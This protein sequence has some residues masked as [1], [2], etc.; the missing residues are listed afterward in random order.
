MIKKTIYIST[1]CSLKLRDNQLV[2]Q[3]NHIKGQEDKADRTA[4]IEDIGF[5]ILEHDQI[6]LSHR[7]IGAMLENN[8]AMITSNTK[9]L[10]TGLLLNLNGNTLQGERFK[11]QI[12]ASEP[13]KKQLW[14]QVIKQKITNQAYLLERES[15]NTKKMTN[16]AD[17][18]L[19]GD[20]GNNEAQAAAYYWQNIFAPSWEFK[21]DRE[22]LPPNNLLNYGYTILRAIMAR[23]LVGAG[24]LPTLGIFHRNRYNAYALADDMMEPYRPFVDKVVLNILSQTSHVDNLTTELK[25]KLLTIPTLDVKIE[26]ETSPLM[27]ATQRTAASLVKCFEGEKRRLLLP[28]ML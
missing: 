20:D 10:P 12:E 16:L 19:S 7:L 17:T 2:V 3:Y 1:P 27:I 26:K 18:V 24:L 4:P 22:G 5:L 9:L 21:R 8:V 13:L 6:T 14:A 28:N 15:R 23:S 11:W 25:S